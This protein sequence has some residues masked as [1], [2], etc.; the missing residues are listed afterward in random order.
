MRVPRPVAA[1]I[2]VLTLWPLVYMF[3]FFAFILNSF[4]RIPSTAKEPNGA[5]QS[6]QL[7]FV[8]HIGTM[9]VIMGLLAFYIVHVFRNPALPESRRVL[10]A[11]VL[12]MGNMVS[13][14]VYWFLYIWRHPVSALA[15]P[16]PPVPPPASAV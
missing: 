5:F 1:L 10:W 12:F 7:L 8:A 6:F 16:L 3:I 13:M 2:G 4:A 14:P 11:V 15:P 9:L